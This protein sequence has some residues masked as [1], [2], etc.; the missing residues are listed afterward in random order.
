MREM[1]PI[2]NTIEPA[3]NSI[4]AICYHYFIGRYA[5]A[6][7]YIKNAIIE[8]GDYTDGDMLIATK[9]YGIPS[10]HKQYRANLKKIVNNADSQVKAEY[11]NQDPHIQQPEEDWF[12]YFLDKAKN[13]SDEEIQK[14]WAY[15]L[16]QECLHPKSCRKVM[17]DKL[18]MLD[19]KMAES[20]GKLCAWTY[21]VSVENNDYSIPLYLRDDV[22]N[23][24]VDYNPTLLTENDLLNYKEERPEEDELELLQGLG[25]LNLSEP[26]DMG[27]VYT[28]NSV[29][30]IVNA[31]GY[32]QCVSG[33]TE[34]KT[35]YFLTGCCT[36][37]K[38]GIDLYNALKKGD[39]ISN[40]NITPILSAFVSY[41]QSPECQNR[42]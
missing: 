7:E 29:D 40:K 35:H 14:I 1:M 21:S 25:F 15:I 13:V 3:K 38:M 8:K 12:L 17:I 5:E 28:K 4:A 10:L 9:L 19:K 2:N 24:I 20:F 41:S 33:L 30:F 27:D 36:Y 18:S 11:D 34:G 42:Y 6:D 23:E 31:Q 39:S 37:T 16:K 32:H 22:I 26:G